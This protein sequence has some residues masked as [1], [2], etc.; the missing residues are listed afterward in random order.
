MQ[1]VLG[2]QERVK[3]APDLASCSVHFRNNLGK[4]LVCVPAPRMAGIHT[5]QQQMLNYSTAAFCTGTLSF[6]PSHHPHW[7]PTDLRSKKLGKL[8]SGSQTKRSLPSVW[9]YLTAP[10]L[11]A[12]QISAT[13]TVSQA[14]SVI[15]TVLTSI[16]LARNNWTWQNSSHPKKLASH[17]SS[18]LIIT[19][20]DAIGPY[21]TKEH[22]LVV[23]MGHKVSS[24]CWKRWPL[25]S[26]SLTRIL[27]NPLLFINTPDSWWS[28]YFC[29]P[30]VSWLIVKIL[31]L[32]YEGASE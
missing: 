18:Y 10:K 17:F 16:K 11:K 32:H 21:K 24:Y 28:L 7:P 27:E 15:K 1:H 9:C 6:V 22:I 13:V 20:Q 14:D 5:L 30:S 19:K 12:H 31:F 3:P 23:Q 4:E 26:A 8:H 2:S 25:T 29:R